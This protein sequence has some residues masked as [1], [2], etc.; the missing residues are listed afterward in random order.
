MKKISPAYAILFSLIGLITHI[1]CDIFRF[2]QPNDP[3]V[4]LLGSLLPILAYLPA[5]IATMILHY[6]CWNAIPVDIARTTPGAAVGLLFVPFFNFYWYFVSYAGL[7]EDCAK[8]LGSRRS[9]RGLGITLGILSIACWTPLAAIPLMIIPLGITY[10]I[11]WLVYTLR[12][13]AG[14]NEL[15]GRE[16][17]QASNLAEQGVAPNT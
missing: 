4:I 13:V 6:R 5:I 12:I 2:D 15:T 7:A 9:S 10:F 14:A 8:A 3:D 11:V 1:T 17:P 16:S